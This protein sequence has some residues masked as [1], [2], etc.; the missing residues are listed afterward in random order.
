MMPNDAV[1][2]IGQ[3]E[4]AAGQDAMNRLLRAAAVCARAESDLR[5]SLEALLDAAIA[6]SA[7]EKGNIQLFDETAGALRLAAQRGFERPF[8]DYFDIVRPGEVGSCGAAIRAAARIAVED[9][10]TSEVFAGQ[11]SLNVLLEAGVRAVQSTPLIASDGAVLGMVSTHFAQPRSF[12]QGVRSRLDLLARLGGDYL[13]RRQA[14]HALRRSQAWLRGQKEAFQASIRGTPLETSLGILVRSALE[15]VGGE[16]RASFFLLNA[17]RTAIHHITGMGEE[18]ARA[19]GGFPVGADAIGCGLAAY[20][21]KPVICPDVLLD[22]TWIPYLPLARRFDYRAT[23]SFPVQNEDG[24]VVGTFCVYSRQPREMTPHDTEVT[25]ALT[26]AA[27]VIMARHQ[28]TQERVRAVEALRDSN[29]R[30]DEFLAMLAHEL[31]NP[32]AAIHGAGQILQRTDGD[33]QTHRSAAE[34]LNRQVGHMVRQVDDLLDVSRISRG[35][36]ELRKE[37]A[38]LAPVVNH[39]VEASFPLRESL[40]HELTVTLPPTSM[41]VH[42]DPIRLAQVVGN[43]MNNACK[44]TDKRG[45]I[46]LT[47]E[48]E[49]A[50]AVIRVRD[51][52]IGIAA[53]ELPRIFDMFSQVDRSLERARDGLGLGLTLVKNLVEMHD[54]TVEAKSA[55]PGRGSEFVVRLPLLSGPPAAQ[56]REPAGVEPVAVV[57]RRVLVVDDNRD[58]ANCVAMM[59]KVLGYE[60]DIA[61]D[62]LEAVERA[63]M[64]QADVILLDIGMPQLNGY[65]AARRIR[66][67]RQE[68]LMLVALTGWGREEDRRLAEEAGFDAHL[69]K[70]VSLTALSKLL[71]ESGSG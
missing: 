5:E 28:A 12:D 40:G 45:R 19:V 14:E 55:G 63:L 16:A 25:T 39:A 10:T 57:P 35:Q 30:K 67:Q 26:H 2:P 36:I 24:K 54:G 61:H 23:W 17:D 13:M 52:G 41:Y 4:A 62:G 49:G 66:A 60:V 22:P 69:V 11:P 18:Y 70:P 50:Q 44:F 71:A 43:L 33:A 51:T 7:A 53:A 42:G 32:L 59:L 9:V 46:W 65:E 1:S 6:I 15:H 38:E 29:Q 47:V 21:G 56:P 31:R 20:T 8:L 58:V 37:H 68:G 3:S 64:S 34:I 48:Q 27:A